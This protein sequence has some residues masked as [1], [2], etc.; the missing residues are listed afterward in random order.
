MTTEENRDE[1]ED[2]VE[3]IEDTLQGIE[4]MGQK[5]I[6]RPY[7]ITYDFDTKHSSYDRRYKS[8]HN[9]LTIYLDYVKVTE[10]SYLLVF[11]GD[12]SDVFRAVKSHFVKGDTCFV[13]Q[14]DLKNRYLY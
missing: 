2:W 6:M 11:P 13:I 8:F 4:D 10:S 5:N 7:I 3:E 9:H 12:A 1:I 14:V